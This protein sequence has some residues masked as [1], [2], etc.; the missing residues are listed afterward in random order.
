MIRCFFH[1][2]VRLPG[3]WTMRRARLDADWRDATG[4]SWGPG[5]PLYHFREEGV[6]VDDSLTVRAPS[7]VAALWI[8]MS[9]G[10]PP[11]RARRFNFEYAGDPATTG[12]DRA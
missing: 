3:G 10:W 4:W 11:I 5:D 7:P 6:G 12:G 1:G 9:E 2:E 8:A